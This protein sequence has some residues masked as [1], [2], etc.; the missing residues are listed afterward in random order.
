MYI[1]TTNSTKSPSAST[2]ARQKLG[3]CSSIGWLSRRL[4]SDQLRTTPSSTP[5]NLLSCQTRW[6]K[7]D[8]L[9]LL[10]KVA[11]IEVSETALG[12]M[13][14]CGTIV[15]IGTGGWDSRAISQSRASAGISQ[16]GAAT[17]C[18]AALRRRS[19]VWDPKGAASFFYQPCPL[20]QNVRK[21]ANV[22]LWRIQISSS[23][24]RLRKSWSGG[25][26]SKIDGSR[27][28]L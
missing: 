26:P 23:Q 16:P 5:T 19:A 28:N 14:G 21:K 24:K 13:L 17:D 2:A 9:L 1:S 18:E 7:G 20:F 10:N 25:P 15:V 27:V 12:R 11:S 6:S 4:S 3:A 8:T 22:I